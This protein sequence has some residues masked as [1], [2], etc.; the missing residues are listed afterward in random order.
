MSLMSHRSPKSHPASRRGFTL[1]EMLV[2]IGIIAVLA[3][4]LLPAVM[5]AVTRVRNGA[6]VLEVKQ[7]ADAVESYKKDK[8]DYPPSFRDADAFVRH[9]RRC[10]PKIAPGELALYVTTNTSGQYVWV[11]PPNPTPVIDEG[12]ALVFWLGSLY[13]DPRYPFSGGPSTTTKPPRKTYYDFNATRLINS[14]GDAYPSYLAKYAKE[15]CYL[16]IDSRSYDN[17]KNDVLDL[18]RFSM[19][20]PA[21]S[22]DTYA[23]FENSTDPE[24]WCRPYWSNTARQPQPTGS[25]LFRDMVLPMNGTTFQIICAGQDGNFGY[26]AAD[27]D[28]K[29]F[30]GGDRYND[31]DN[32]NITN[33]SRGKLVDEIP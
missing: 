5:Y 30:P 26:D 2:V 28:A 33:F 16:Y 24:H 8:G 32:D 23:T 6:I 13:N 25:S 20:S 9:V 4:L 11:T 14:D 10:Y 22:S 19:G 29:L 21:D 12:E 18:G 15:T 31:A 7:L 3:A 1:V 27:I 17:P